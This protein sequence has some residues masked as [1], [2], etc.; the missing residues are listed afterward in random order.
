MKKL[1]ILGI[2]LLNV[3]AF[4]SDKGNGGSGSESLL[5]GQQ[6]QLESVALKLRSFFLKNETALKPIFPE[7]NIQDLAKKIKISDIRVVDETKLI[8]KYGKSRT[9][10]NFP[11]SSLIECKSSGVEPLFNQP[12]TLFVLV[13]HEYL[14]LIGVEE[15]SPANPTMIAGY[16]ISKRIAP[17]VSKVNDYDL[18]IA[19]KIADARD[20]HSVETISA[21]SRISF[22]KDVYLVATKVRHNQIGQKCYLRSYASAKDRIIYA[23]QTFNITLAASVQTLTGW[24]NFFDLTHSEVQDFQLVCNTSVTIKELKSDLASQGIELELASL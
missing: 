10:L 19:N 24:E 2:L 8:D 21:G 5:V 12:S 6:A 15:T 13:L 17:Y 16:S 4:A 7:F 9:C 23:P 14:G 18:V 3:Q 1:L 22:K 20:L 11:N